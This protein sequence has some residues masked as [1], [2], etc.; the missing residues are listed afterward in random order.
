ML[1]TNVADNS[2]H[3]RGEKKCSWISRSNWK[4]NFTCRLIRIDYTF[5]LQSRRAALRFPEPSLSVKKKFKLSK[6][7]LLLE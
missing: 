3:F 2:K 6:H 5:P 1:H 4:L 7:F